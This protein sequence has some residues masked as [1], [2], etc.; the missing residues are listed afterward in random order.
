MLSSLQES[1][2][3]QFRSPSLLVAALTHPSYTHDHPDSGES[4]QR[5]EFLGDAVLQLILTEALFLHFPSEREGVLS[6][7]RSAL[8]KGSFLCQLAREVGLDRHLRLGQSEESTG[9]R[10]RDSNLEDAF[11]A[12]IGACY[13]DQGLEATRA[14]TLRLIG[15]L[16]QRLQ[17][18]DDIENPKGRLQEWAQPRHGNAAL[19]YESTHVSGQDHAREYAST[20]FLFEQALGSGRGTSKKAA[21]E[22]AARAALAQL[23]TRPL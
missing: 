21:E 14:L 7:S 19:R 17:H 3:F 2:C 6:K 18:R 11:E 20:V 12:L 15:S 23:D 8:S 10:Q 22:A 13:L 4:Y 5:L 16:E 9:G 1:L